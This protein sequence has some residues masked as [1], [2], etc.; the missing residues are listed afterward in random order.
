MGT[1]TGAEDGR[2]RTKPRH[3][4]PVPKL[5]A[6]TWSLTVCGETFD[7]G[8]HTLSWDQVLALPVRRVDTHITCGEAGVGMSGRWGGVPVSEILHLVPPAAGVT[9]VLVSAAYGFSSTV[10]L[11][12]LQRDDALLVFELDGEPLPPEHGGPMRLLV[13][14]LFGY[15]NV[16]WVLE[17]SYRSVPEPGF[18]E[19][20]GYHLVGE[21]VDGYLYGH[22]GP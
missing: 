13:P 7:A 12:D 16:K 4:G 1:D 21:V 15:K 6:D 11:A 3:Y 10:R 14:H 9:S 5:S 8:V 17:I 2:R 20:R 22:Q 19:S 18:W